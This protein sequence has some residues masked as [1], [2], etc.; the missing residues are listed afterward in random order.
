MLVPVPHI[1]FNTGF[2][3]DNWG[4]YNFVLNDSFKLD[5]NF[6]MY[7]SR[8]VYHTNF[9]SWDFLHLQNLWVV[10]YDLL[11]LNLFCC[12]IKY[13]VFTIKLYGLLHIPI[14]EL[15]YCRFIYNGFFFLFCFLI[16]FLSNR[17]FYLEVLIE[18]PINSGCY[19]SV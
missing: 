11:L 9:F 8:G 4:T 13:Y 19:Y 1:A 18:W 16:I 12:V 17:W 14:C 2:H 10:K 15:V 3:D 6:R 7:R 5:F